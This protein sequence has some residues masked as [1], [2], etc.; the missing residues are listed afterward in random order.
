MC[1]CRLRVPVR[2]AFTHVDPGTFILFL[3][4]REERAV[5]LP[6]TPAFDSLFQCNQL[7]PQAGR[8]FG[9]QVMRRLC[10]FQP[11]GLFQLLFPEQDPSLP[12]ASGERHQEEKHYSGDKLHLLLQLEG[13]SSRR[14]PAVTDIAGVAAR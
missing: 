13:E 11:L 3:P 5:V 7:F 4:L 8:C 12:D 6:A 1:G 9:Q 2:K 14:H 10:I